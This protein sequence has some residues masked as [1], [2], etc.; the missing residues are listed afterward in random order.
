MKIV[1]IGCGAGGGTSAQFARKINRK[2]EII[3]YDKEG[4]GQYSK[5]ALPFII[6]GKNW[7]DIVEFPPNWFEKNGIE[8]RNEEIYKINFDG[9][10]VEGE[11]E[12][13]FDVLIVASGAEPCSP[14]RAENVYFFRTLKDAIE[15]KNIALKSEKAIVVGAGLIGLEVAEALFNAGI[16]VTILEYMPYILPSMLDKDM[17]DYLMKKLPVEIK[18]NCRVEKAEDKK[19]FADEEHK[20]DFVIVATGN[21]PNSFNGEAIKV[22][23]KCRAFENVYACGDCTQ[24]KDFFGRYVNVG[25]GSISARQGRVAGINAGGGNEIMIPPVFSKTTKIFGIEIAS[26]GLLSHEINGIYARYAGKDLPHY[27]N[28]EEIVVKIVADKNGKIV[29]SQAIGRGASKI[30]DRIALAIYNEM[31]AG[32]ISRIENAYAPAVAPTFDAV[33][34]ACRMIERKLKR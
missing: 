1:I 9:R 12:E 8:Y 4:Y 14:F 25:L 31:N 27:M 30:I 5:C 17:A 18:L 24:I 29:G 19:V 7:E 21:K 2:A 3:V 11:K 34:I 32:Q 23:E 28:G 13:E 33:E 10:T 16:N 20:A 15:V 22:D 6:S 26:T